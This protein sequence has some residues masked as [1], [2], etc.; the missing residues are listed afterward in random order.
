MLSI[1]QRGSRKRA[2]AEALRHL[3]EEA[4]LSEYEQRR[5]D[6]IARNTRVLAAMG[7]TRTQPRRKKKLRFET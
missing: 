3:P 7:L 6:N 5:A 2:A 4:V 1:A